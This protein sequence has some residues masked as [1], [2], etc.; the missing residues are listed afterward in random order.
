M[1]NGLYLSRKD[2]FHDVAAI[3]QTVKR[4]ITKKYRTSWSVAGL[5]QF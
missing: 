4:S 2:M 3:N 5:D 1:M